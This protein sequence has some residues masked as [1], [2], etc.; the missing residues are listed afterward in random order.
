MILGQDGLCKDITGKAG[1]G[2]DMQEEV[3]LIDCVSDL[4]S[5]WIL[6]VVGRLDCMPSMSARKG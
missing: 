2:K 3:A 5:S 4:P 1:P 6:T